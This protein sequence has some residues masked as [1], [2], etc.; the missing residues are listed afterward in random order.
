MLAP[1]EAQAP[2]TAARLPGITAGRAAPEGLHIDPA[3][4]Q[5][6]DRAGRLVSAGLPLI[7]QG[8][9]GTGKSLFARTAA[10]RCFGGEGDLVFIDC[11][12]L[13][14]GLE[15]GGMLHACLQRPRACL[16]FDR[17]GELGEAGQAA[18]LG[19][20]ESGRQAGGNRL[21]IVA[22]AAADLDRLRPDLL[23][24][25]KGG[26]ITLPP[27]RGAPDLDGTLHA[28]FRLECAALGK[29]AL[30]L[31]EEV[32]RVL[33]AYHWPGNLRQA[34]LALRHA[35]AL[36]DGASVHLSH[37]PAEIVEQVARKDM[38]AR[39]QSEAARIE[40][41]L[42]YNGG[43]VSLTAKYLGVSRATLYRKIQ[44]GKARGEG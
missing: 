11:T 29:P 26:A 18:L 12:T 42:R 15:A 35:A 8:E 25:L 30:D 4:A 16:I 33:A 32:R 38:T 13:D 37:L 31:D 41:A 5:L 2:R 43:N 17:I 7:V 3:L 1:P 40:A 36:A 24:R 20:L 10:R 19:L 22:I 44:I 14:R 21:G 6:I 23:H 34:R 9:T 27:L 28:L 39:S